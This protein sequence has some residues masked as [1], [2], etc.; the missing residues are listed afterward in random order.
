MKFKI[1]SLPFYQSRCPGKTP[2]ECFQKDII[3]LLDPLF[4]YDLVEGYR[5]RGAGCVPILFQ[6]YGDLVHGQFQPFGRGAYNPEIRLMRDQHRELRRFYFVFLKCVDH[7]FL[8]R[9]DSYL[10]RLVRSE[11]HTSELQS[12]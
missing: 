5:D 7:E 6:V 10:E 1:L 4:P 3:V 12:H 2:A 8:K 9:P 11:E